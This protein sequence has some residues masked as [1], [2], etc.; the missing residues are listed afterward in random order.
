MIDQGQITA[1]HGKALLRVND[2]N[3]YMYSNGTMVIH[4]GLLSALHT[5]DELVAILSHEIA[6]F[7]LDHSVQNVNIY[8]LFRRHNIKFITFPSRLFRF[9]YIVC[10]YLLY[11]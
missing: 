1:G 2:E 3:V 7:V 4:T 5:E 11:G 10:P 8:I 9:I 6:H